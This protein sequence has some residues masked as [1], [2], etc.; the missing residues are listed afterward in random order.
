MKRRPVNLGWRYDAVLEQAP[1]CIRQRVVA[2]GAFAIGDASD[3]DRTLLAGVVG[4]GSEWD[5]QRLLNR[6]NTEFFIALEAFAC[7]CER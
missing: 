5:A 6:V 4:D 2:K 7:G 1:V 3:N